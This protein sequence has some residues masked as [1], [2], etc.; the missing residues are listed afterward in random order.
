MC[1]RYA[2]HVKQM[3]QWAELLQDWP[4]NAETSFNIAPTQMVPAF[5]AEHGE[6]MRWG[7]IPSWSQEPSS[8]FATF[9]ARA[10]SVAEK[11]AFRNA[12]R[13]SQTCLVPAIGYYEWK[14]TKGQKQPYFIYSKNG[15][16]LVM[17]GLWEYWNRGE[18]SIYSCTVITQPSHG[19]L[20]EVHTRMPLMPE[21]EQAE[22][23]VNDGVLVFDELMQKQ[24][25]ERFAFH[26]V[27]KN[28]NKSSN[29]GE[30]LIAPMTPANT[31]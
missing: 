25:I 24:N 30:Q 18:Q 2:N 5:T 29:Q 17:A 9:N 13:K 22:R 7:M 28:V 8:K 23:W 1:G 11:P 10:E 14:G 31:S 4:D 16:P 3:G 12:W 15:E 27:N 26:P 20:S 6:A 21:L 19:K